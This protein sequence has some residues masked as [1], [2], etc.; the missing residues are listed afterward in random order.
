[1][2][3]SCGVYLS[4]CPVSI[5]I[6]LA[7]LIILVDCVGTSSTQFMLCGTVHVRGQT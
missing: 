7:S 5:A 2:P 3:S 1:M 6:M 4:N